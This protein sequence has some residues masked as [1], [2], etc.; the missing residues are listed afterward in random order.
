MK[1]YGDE[2]AKKDG[3]EDLRIKRTQRAIKDAFYSLVEE[4]GFEHI[5]VKDITERAMISRNTFYLHYE[6]KYDLLNKISYFFSL[7]S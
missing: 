5:T 7:P 3:S 4:K 2:M 6:D 1:G